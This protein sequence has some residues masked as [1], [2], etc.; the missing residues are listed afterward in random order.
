MLNISSHP[1]AKWQPAQIAAANSQIQGLPED[2]QKKFSNV[3]PRGPVGPLAKELLDWAVSQ[4]DRLA[5]VQG[6]AR[7]TVL[8]VP[9]LVD[10][11]FTVV[12]G[13][14]ERVSIETIQDDGSLKK[15]QVFNFVAFQRYELFV[16]SDDLMLEKCKAGL[17]AL[18]V[19]F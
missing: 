10:A 8:L 14:T 1:S 6:E 2:L 17:R 7:I 19:D 15:T 11:G 3:D 12:A 4:P 13:T 5:M 9:M 16:S 18:G